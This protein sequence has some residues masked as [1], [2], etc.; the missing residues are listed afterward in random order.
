M[1]LTF[2][3]GDLHGRFDLLEAALTAIEARADGGTIIFLGDYV[4][5]GPQSRQVIERLMVGPP[6]GWQWVCLMGNHE[7]MLVELVKFPRIGM[8]RF[9]ING[10]AATVASYGAAAW[11]PGEQPPIP[12]AHVAWLADLPLMHVDLH[13]VYVHAALDRWRPL[14]RQR[15]QALLWDLYPDDEGGHGDFH[16]VHGHHQVAAGPVLKK[17]RTTSTPAPGGPA[18]SWW[19]CSTTTGRAERLSSLR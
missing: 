5:R 8:S 11:N 1:P 17:H 18:G 16:V 2:A 19:G 6:A 12:A 10:G 4:D 13:R 14:H 7:A 15:E 9:L 3:I